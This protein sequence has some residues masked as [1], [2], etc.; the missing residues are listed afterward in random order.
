[1]GRK[2]K[3]SRYLNEMRRNQRFEERK[4]SI[5]VRG[6]APVVAAGADLGMNTGG[7]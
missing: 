5:V 4:R 3:K 1:M 2:K 6:G 7:G